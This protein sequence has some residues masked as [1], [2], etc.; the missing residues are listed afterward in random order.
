MTE[1]DEDKKLSSERVQTSL[2]AASEK[3]AL[4]WLA[5][6]L[7]RWVTPD[8]LTFLGLVAM[9]GIGVAYYVS[10]R[11]YAYLLAASFG[12]VVNWFGDSL[13]GTLAR[14]RKMERPKYGYYLDHLVDAFGTSFMLLGLAYSGFMSPPL[15]IAL[16]TLYLIMSINVYL[17]THTVG[18]F[19]ISF[20]RLSPTEGRILLIVL[21]ITLI[22]AKD[23]R[24]FSWRVNIL[25]AIA[26]IAG[27]LLLV[28]ILRNAVRNLSALN[29]TERAAW[30]HRPES[31]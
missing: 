13:D 31:P 12:L 6:R 17:A 27:I 5:T 2:L 14:V 11:H 22:F 7:P 3:R 19:N 20:A 9:V 30:D 4:V 29:R 15:G 21:N 28:L 18:V 1:E 10:A 23:V 8:Q 26:G 25:D 24:V 16:L